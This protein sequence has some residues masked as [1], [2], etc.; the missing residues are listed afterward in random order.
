MPSL[1]STL[2]PMFERMTRRL[3]STVCSSD[4]LSPGL[5]LVTARA[6]A[7]AFPAAGT[8][9]GIRVSDRDFRHYTVYSVD[10]E[11]LRIVID[12]RGGG[13][14]AKWAESLHPGDELQILV[15]GGMM[16]RV[17]PGTPLILGDA[18]AIAT[19]RA[20]KKRY[21]TAVAA[22]EVD[23]TDVK[24]ANG[25]LSHDV[26][27]LPALSTPGSAGAQWLARTFDAPNRIGGVHLAGHAQSLQRWRRTVRERATIDR[28]DVVTQAHWA[29]GRT[30]L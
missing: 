21:P 1:P 24:A 15:P 10:A 5:I 23:G 18:T 17:G 29:D 30:G 25:L 26:E 27:V 11:E 6:S 9:F 12:L 28:H 3:T 4:R 20:F 19:L 22:I 8:H 13:P 14:G 16:R 7:G 2:A